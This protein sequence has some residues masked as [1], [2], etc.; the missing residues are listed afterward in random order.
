[1]KKGKKMKKNQ[2]VSL[3]YACING[4]VERKLN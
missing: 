4:A 3:L 2:I 1:M